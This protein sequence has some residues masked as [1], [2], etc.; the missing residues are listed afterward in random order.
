MTFHHLMRD[1]HEYAAK[2]PLGWLQ[3]LPAYIGLFGCLFMV[4]A[5][6]SSL[7]WSSSVTA[8]KILGAF[9][10]VS[11]FQYNPKRKPEMY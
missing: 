4:F 10:V 5:C 9:G 1:S 6:G 3:P 8:A 2:T 7:W 11:A